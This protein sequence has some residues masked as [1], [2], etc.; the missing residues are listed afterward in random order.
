MTND[1]NLPTKLVWLDLEMTGLDPLNDVILEVALNI[2][3]FEFNSLAT[4]EAR[5]S[6]DKQQVEEKMGKN[7]FWDDFPKNK[8]QFL[9]GLHEGKPI[10]QIEDELCEL[11]KKHFNN[12]RAVLAGNT[13]YNDRMFIRRWLPKFN[14][15]LHY[16]MLDVSSWKV[17]MQG[18]YAVEYKKQETHRAKNDIKE[19][20]EE[21]QFYVDYL[22]RDGRG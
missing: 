2:T 17:Y 5:V 8:D 16:R 9:A 22:H 19:S 21:L 12:E 14:S 1:N 10:E 13:I 18:K 6:H 11:V 20:M 7:P 3:D 15:L 4:Y